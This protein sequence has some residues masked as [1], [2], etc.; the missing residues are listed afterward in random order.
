MITV[1]GLAIDARYA[2][3]EIQKAAFEKG[4][5]PYIPDEKKKGAPKTS[6]SENVLQ[7]SLKTQEK[8]KIKTE[9]TDPS[10]LSL[11]M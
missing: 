8:K 2:P 1:D 5:I 3:R 11:D 4:L 9:Y 10:Q 7:E 6:D